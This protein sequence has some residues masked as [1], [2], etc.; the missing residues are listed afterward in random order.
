MI[1]E[2]YPS[3]VRISGK[4]LDRRRRYAEVPAPVMKLVIL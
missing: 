1:E 2:T 3:K 4:N